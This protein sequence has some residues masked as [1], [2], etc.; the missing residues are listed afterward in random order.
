VSAFGKVLLLS[1]GVGG[2][3]LAHGLAQALP[4][5][6]LTVIVNTGDDLVHWGLYVCPDIDTVMYTLAGRADEARGWGLADETF[7][8]LSAMRELGAPAWFALGDRDLATHLWR[9]E[10]LRRGVSLSQVTEQLCG[11][12]G[13]ASRVLPMCDAPRR[14][15][16]ETHD[17]GVLSFQ[18]WL[19]E[20]RA[21]PVR[22]LRFEG[23][24]QPSPA[25]LAAIADAELVVI[26]PSNPYVSID[27]ILGLT[28][29]REQLAGKL[30]V[31]LSPIVHG[32]A[33]KGPLADM[34]RTL[35]ERE[36]SAAA[37]ADHYRGML[38]GIVVERGD[39]AT[40][41]TPRV[42]GTDTV[43]GGSADRA[44]LAREVLRF[45]EGLR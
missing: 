11:L 9:S 8:V 39:E 23:L 2:A 22:A 41:D 45:A 25:V 24:D 19:V 16:V 15:L 3:R 32:R 30:L 42:L 33:V 10:A 26:G 1:G 21:P 31:A 43:M 27:P 12:L 37:I 38:S 34:I 4:E 7:G 17:Q 20:R 28:G 14:T 40:I 36:P 5:G 18:Q 44:R 6:A 35:A 29:V 13:V